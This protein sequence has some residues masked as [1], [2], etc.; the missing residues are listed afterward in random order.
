MRDRS[1]H[2]MLAAAAWLFAGAAAAQAPA[3]VHQVLADAP[4]DLSVTVYRAPGRNSGSFNLD[5]LNGFALIRE[6]RQVR[7][8]AGVEP[9]PLRRRGGW[10]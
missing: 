5:G 4:T 6:T 9:H 10:H 1:P 8:P 2:R 7:V 3:D